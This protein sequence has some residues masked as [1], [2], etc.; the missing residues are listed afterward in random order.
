MSD[1]EEELIAQRDAAIAVTK[2][3]QRQ[4]QQH[5]EVVERTFERRALNAERLRFHAEEQLRRTQDE[6]EWEATMCSRLLYMSLFCGMIGAIIGWCSGLLV[7]IV[8]QQPLAGFLMI[9]PGMALGAGM[10]LAIAKVGGA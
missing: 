5:R 6:R 1:M 9:L 8:F 4:L 3:L 10:G 2:E 7:F